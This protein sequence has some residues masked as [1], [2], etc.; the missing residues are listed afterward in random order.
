MCS[1]EYALMFLFLGWLLVFAVKYVFVGLAAWDNFFHPERY[2]ADTTGP[3]ARFA[4]PF[5]GAFS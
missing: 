1:W 5:L 3:Y 4:K 2:V